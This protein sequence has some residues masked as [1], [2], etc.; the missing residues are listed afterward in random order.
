MIAEARKFDEIY[1]KSLMPKNVK[2][3][4]PFPI[5]L[6]IE[7][8][9]DTKNNLVINTGN[10]VFEFLHAND[11]KH[12]VILVNPNYYF[13]KMSADYEALVDTLVQ[14]KGKVLLI[15]QDEGIFQKINLDYLN[16]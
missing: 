13:L 9:I 5:S 11:L 8:V 3:V 14:L 4:L 16:Q 12:N 1:L 2:L 6:N 7:S 15:T 10:D